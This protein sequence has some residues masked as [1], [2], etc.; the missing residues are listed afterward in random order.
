MT[1]QCERCGRF[2]RPADLSTPSNRR[3]WPTS[4]GIMNGDQPPLWCPQ[5]I[6]TVA[7]ANGAPA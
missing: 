6:D 2:T 5:C 7:D 3:Y 4:F 1:P